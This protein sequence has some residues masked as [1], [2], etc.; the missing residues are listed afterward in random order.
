MKDHLKWSKEKVTFSLI[1]HAATHNDLQA[2][3]K[4]KSNNN[5]DETGILHIRGRPLC[6]TCVHSRRVYLKNVSIYIVVEPSPVRLIS[7]S[8]SPPVK[9]RNWFTRISRSVVHCSS[10]IINNNWKCQATLQ[11]STITTASRNTQTIFL[12][13]SAEKCESM[14]K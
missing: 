5:N 3:N 10:N 9:H 8:C 7:L 4:N 6:A 1:S 12:Y 14:W 13:S 2:I 11:E